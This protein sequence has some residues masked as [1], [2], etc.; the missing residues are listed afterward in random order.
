[1]N[2]SFIPINLRYMNKREA[3]EFLGCSPRLIN[4]ALA[5][6]SLQGC[7]PRRNFLRF[8]LDQLNDFMKGQGNQANQ[9]VS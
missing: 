4:L 9:P 5:N 1:M 6:G 8:R 3:A 7:R 2:K